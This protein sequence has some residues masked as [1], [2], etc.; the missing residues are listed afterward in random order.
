MAVRHYEQKEY[1]T[2]YK[3]SSQQSTIEGETQTLYGVADENR[4][5]CDFTTDIGTAEAAVKFLNENNV[6]P[7]HV[8]EIIEDLF[9]SG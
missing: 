4:F 8:Y 6:E 1:Q 7:C 5:Y 2:M 3:T 9:Y